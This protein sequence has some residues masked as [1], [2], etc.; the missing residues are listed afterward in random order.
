MKVLAA[1]LGGTKTLLQV[2]RWTEETP[3]VL[4]ERRYHSSGYPSF[5]VLLQEFLTEV[6]DIVSNLAG[7]CFAV[8][9]PVAKGTA[10]VTNLSWRLEEECLQKGFGLPQVTL[11]NDFQAI[12]YGI[13]SL[14]PA[15]FAVLQAGVPEYA[16]PQAVIGAGTGLGQ[17]LLVWQE[18]AGHYQVLPTEGGHVDFAP[19]GELQIALLGYLSRHLEHVSYERLLSGSG[20][21]T[22]YRFLKET[23]GETEDLALK[24][25]LEEGDPA[26]AIS[27][28]ALERRDPLA[29]RA[30]DLLARIYGAQAGNLALTCLPRGG[31]F[32]AGGIA[33]KIIECLQAGGFM[34]A[35]LSKGRLSQL[36][37]QIPVKVILEPKVG[38]WGASRVAARLANEKS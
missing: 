8:A 29:G 2:T 9:G 6:G 26:A 32:V 18:Q 28:F 3:Q 21:V 30:L 20:L 22:L 4:A 17:A 24:K 16:A 38:L 37:R 11:I 25:A 36:L 23:S 12:G 7:A 10:E 27:R 13:E 31:L 35:F 1:D 15:D 33:P 14:K 5:D 34:E 19:R